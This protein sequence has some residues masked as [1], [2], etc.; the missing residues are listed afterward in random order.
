MKNIIHKSLIL[1]AAA[2]LAACSSTPYMPP[3]EYPL[4][5]VHSE[6]MYDWDSDYSYAKNI[7]MMVRPSGIGYGVDDVSNPSDAVLVTKDGVSDSF[8]LGGSYL[9]GGIGGA[10][11][12]GVLNNTV[13]KQNNWA[14]ILV[15]FIPVADLPNPHDKGAYLKLRNVVS[16][17]IRAAL[18]SQYK[19]MEWKGAYYN[20]NRWASAKSKVFF[21]DATCGD[22]YN[23]GNK[24]GRYPLL[25]RATPHELFED[26]GDNKLVAPYCGFTFESSITGK[27]MID[28]VEHWII[29]S[30]TTKANNSANNAYYIQALNKAYSGHILNPRAFLFNAL[31]SDLKNVKDRSWVNKYP[32]VTH[33]GETHLFDEDDTKK[34][35]QF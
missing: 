4:V 31:S 28:G 26:T 7:S 3:T 32:F 19:D 29:T 8:A 25:A 24:G 15:D 23:M 13:E 35:L 21:N 34:T 30:L 27:A 11:L 12:F 17:N 2:G 10:L 1:I 5:T 9:E 20:T 14:P 16:N 22:A 33:Q 18:E 6:D